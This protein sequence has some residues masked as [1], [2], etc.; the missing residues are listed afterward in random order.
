MMFEVLRV[1]LLHQCDWM[2]ERYRSLLA[3]TYSKSRQ[4]SK[5]NGSS[6]SNANHHRAA[7]HTTSLIV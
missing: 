7:W 4:S 5:E 1:F 3:Q 2:S 6:L